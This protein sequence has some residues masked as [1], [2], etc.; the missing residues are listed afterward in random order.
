MSGADFKTI[1]LFLY[2]IPTY[3]EGL[4]LIANGLFSN[5]STI[6]YTLSI[7]KSILISNIGKQAFDKLNIMLKF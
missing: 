2:L 7:L 1:I 6:E 5:S 3:K 4:H